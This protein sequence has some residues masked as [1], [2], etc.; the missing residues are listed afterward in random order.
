MK[1]VARAGA[2]FDMIDMISWI[3]LGYVAFSVLFGALMGFKR[4]AAKAGLRIATVIIAAVAGFF[5]VRMLGNFAISY[6]D[7]HSLE[8]VIK[9]FYSGYDSL[10]SYVREIISSM[11]PNVLSHI[12]AI[13]VFLI[14]VPV[15]YCIVFLIIKFILWMIF[16]IVSAILGMSSYKK[17]AGSRIGGA[18]IGMAQSIIIVVVT[19]L[20]FAGII[21][22]TDD[23]KG[24]LTSDNVDDTTKQAVVD[25]YDTYYLDDIADYPVF[26]IVSACGGD[27][28]YR[29]L[30][31]VELDDTKYYMKDLT[32]KVAELYVDAMDL[33]DLDITHPEL[34][35]QQINELIEHA[36]NT[37]RTDNHAKFTAVLL[38]STIRS[39]ALSIEKTLDEIAP[40]E[41][42]YRTLVVDTLHM[43]ESSTEDNLYLDLT[44]IAE[45]YYLFGEQNVLYELQNGT[46]ES[47]LNSLI[48]PIGDTIVIDK[49]I[50]ILRGDS[51]TEPIVNSLAS[52]SIAIMCENLNMDE[53]T[54]QVYEN[55]KG[56][57]NDI[58][59]L[60]KED[61]TS[62][63]AYKADVKAELNDTLT[64]NGIELDD[65]VID[66]MTDY[67]AENYSDT[68]E[69]TDADV[70]DAIL[71]YYAA[72]ADAVE[73]GEIE[74]GELPDNIEDL[75]PQS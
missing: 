52:I 45:V 13:P 49:G 36:T 65:E 70:N 1:G 68:D 46:R 25:F 22:L 17:G 19:F 61:Y 43:F 12:L 44:T 71:S 55:V 34:K 30:T 48:A 10:P 23:V 54:L 20:P 51:R 60:N 4:G 59:A 3:L 47:L 72:Y 74:E 38:S 9:I 42:P 28:L 29:G 5:I 21:S 58:L 31:K 75:I 53:N 32:V 6:F 66:G 18:V 24:A 35:K 15:V 2:F 8:D 26:R 40:M 7:D 33:A 27:A 69:I 37:S 39:V 56:G 14:I 67:I 57:V 50:D 62:E 64:D 41:E 63:E 11:D 16:A 73:K